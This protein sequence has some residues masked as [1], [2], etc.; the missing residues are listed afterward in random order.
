M[1]SG[2]DSSRQCRWSSPPL[3][4]WR[5]QQVLCPILS[6]SCHSDFPSLLWANC[7]CFGLVKCWMSQPL[8][9]SLGIRGAV[10]QNIPSG[11]RESQRQVQHSQDLSRPASLLSHQRMMM[12]WLLGTLKP[13]GGTLGRDSLP[14]PCPYHGFMTLNF[15]ES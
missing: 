8:M 13:A 2:A 5:G 6:A 7:S 15:L 12:I 11:V 14:L 3:L 9:Q 4:R 10:N 1:F